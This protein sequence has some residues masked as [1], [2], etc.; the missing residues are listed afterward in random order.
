MRVFYLSGLLLTLAGVPLIQTPAYAASAKAADVVEV[1]QMTWPELK[2]ALA[3]GKTTALFYT[4]GTEQRGP[5]NII[6]GHNVI[7]REMVKHIAQK[8]GN[9]LAMPVLPYTPA[10]ADPANPG[11]I[12]L[13]ADVLGLVLEKI[14]EQAIA[15][16]FKTVVLMGDSGGGQGPDGVYA[17]VAKKLDTKYSAQGAH[18]YY[19]DHPYTAARDAFNKYLTDKGYPVGFHGGIQDT[20]E[21]M[22]L[23]TLDGNSNWVRKD[24]LS[25]TEGDPVVNGKLQAGPNSPH[26][27]I[28]GDARR[29]TVELG[30]MRHE[31]KVDYA[32]KQIQG[33]MAAQK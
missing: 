7:G 25:I 33:F 9:A 5:Q 28:S 3:A 23:E 27:G 26:N 14:S 2:A 29:S 1:D 8:L 6:A 19:A 15:N 11:N 20:S 22:Y 10:N 4:G 17:A 18:V 21:M 13:P 24:K 16:G 32:V 12:G 31:M 30:K